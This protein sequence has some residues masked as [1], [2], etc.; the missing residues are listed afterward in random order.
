L[1][2]P[3][4]TVK[5][6]GLLIIAACLSLLAFFGLACCCPMAFPIG[7]WS[8]PASSGTGKIAVPKLVITNPAENEVTD[9][10]QIDVKGLTDSDAMLTVNG[11]DITVYSDG[12]FK[13]FVDLN[14]GENTLVFEAKRPGGDP[15][16]REITVISSA[17]T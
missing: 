10:M 9:S 5:I 7:D 12:S 1:S 15:M 14:P 2:T 8:Q 17:S 3:S 6:S 13:G 11:K 4:K 16:T